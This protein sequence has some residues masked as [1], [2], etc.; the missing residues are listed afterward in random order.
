MCVTVLSGVDPGPGHM[1]LAFAAADVLLDKVPPPLLLPHTPTHS[2]THSC[3]FITDTQTHTATSS[4]H[5]YT[6]TA[7][8]LSLSRRYTHPTVSAVGNDTHTHTHTGAPRRAPSPR[9]RAAG[10]ARHD[11]DRRQ[12]IRAHTWPPRPS[13][14][15]PPLSPRGLA[16]GPHLLLVRAGSC[17]RCVCVRVC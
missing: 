14:L 9:G 6:H 4:S 17:V 11:H 13:R 2:R 10:A 1:H 8:C 7:S 15:R 12:K 16:G 3:Q 5:T